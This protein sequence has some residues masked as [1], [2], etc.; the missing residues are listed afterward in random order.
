MMFKL[1]TSVTL[2][3][4]SGAVLVYGLDSDP[5]APLGAMLA[6]FIGYHR[7]LTL[8]DGSIPLVRVVTAASQSPRV[9]YTVWG[10]PL[11][12]AGKVRVSERARNRATN[13]PLR[14]TLIESLPA[15]LR[16]F[17]RKVSA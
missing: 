8:P 16:W 15:A 14:T 3:A 11:A 13:A 5:T 9:R 2:L 4:V 6:L 7:N 12:R 1:L 10:I 17:V